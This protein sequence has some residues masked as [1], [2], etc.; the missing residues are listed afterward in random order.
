L[1]PM[2]EKICYYEATKRTSKPCMDRL[3]SRSS[4]APLQFANQLSSAMS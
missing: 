4:A 3:C 2:P 1:R